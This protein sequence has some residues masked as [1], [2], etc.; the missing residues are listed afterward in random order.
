M[1]ASLEA[2][3]R[4]QNGTRGVTV[5]GRRDA[6]SQFH[7]NVAWCAR[8]WWIQVTWLRA[9]S[10]QPPACPSKTTGV[11][12]RPF[13]WH[14]LTSK[15]LGWR[16]SS[17]LGFVWRRQEATAE[18]QASGITSFHG[19]SR[20]QRACH[21]WLDVEGHQTLGGFGAGVPLP[22]EGGVLLLGRLRT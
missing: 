6:R 2:T 16:S 8:E 9:E 21:D 11:R 5:E 15:V 10:S 17:D 20:R 1:R 3:S 18:S 22:S 4:T 7:V 12:R 13:R 19:G 14:L